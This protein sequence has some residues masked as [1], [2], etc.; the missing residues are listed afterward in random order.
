MY[1]PINSRASDPCALAEYLIK[2]NSPYPVTYI[3]NLLSSGTE[4]TVSLNKPMPIHIQYWTAWIDRDGLLQFRKDI[5]NR[6]GI[7]YKAL[8]ESPPSRQIIK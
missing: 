1:N 6:D 7:L 8:T 5:Y 2:N 4:Q 3:Q